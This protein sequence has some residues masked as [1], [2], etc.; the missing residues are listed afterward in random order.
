MFR[1]TTELPR[2]PGHDVTRVGDD[3]NDSVWAVL[4]QLRDDA[5]EDFDVLLHKVEAC[6]SFL[7]TSS[8]RDDN[9]TR[10]LQP[11]FNSYVKEILH[12]EATFYIF[13]REEIKGLR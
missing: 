3:D 12:E 13:L 1:Q 4:D 5:L 2:D 10:I 9:Y 7:L 11:Q 8:R 6:F